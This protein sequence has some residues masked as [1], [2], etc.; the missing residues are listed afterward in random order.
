MTFLCPFQFRYGTS[1]DTQE[2]LKLEAM[3]RILVN[4]RISERWCQP[5]VNTV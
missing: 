4:W 1:K 3:F 5:I 2:K